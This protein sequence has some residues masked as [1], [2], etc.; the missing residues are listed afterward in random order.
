[1]KVAA[2]GAT[3]ARPLS[4][5]LVAVTQPTIPGVEASGGGVDTS[6]I[7]ASGGR[8]AGPSDGAVQ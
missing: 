2:D 6:G 5:L 1:M 3:G 4:W 8:V 7:P